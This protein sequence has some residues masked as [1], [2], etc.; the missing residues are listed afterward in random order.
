MT[1]IGIFGNT[2]N[3]P[4]LLATGFR[5]LG[6]QVKLVVD[7]PELLHRPEAKAGDYSTSYPDW[8]MDCAALGE[9]QFIAESPRICDAIN[10][11]SSGCRATVLNHIGPSLS[12]RLRIPALS[13]LSGS[14]L[15]YYADYRS[16]EMR[17]SR[18]SPDFVRSAGGRLAEEKWIEFVSR[19]RDGILSSMAVSFPYPGLVPEGD[20]LLRSIGVSD[21]RRFFIYIADT[22]NLRPA[23]LRKADKTKLILLNG[24]RLTWKKPL[25][26]G[27][28][29]Q[30]DKGTDI[31]LRGFAEFVKQ[32]RKGELRMF[33]KG[34]H[35]TETELL[36]QEL[37]IE[38]NIT[39]I[40]ELP[41]AGFWQAMREADVVCDQLGASFPGMVAL[42]AMA[43]GRPVLAN[44]RLDIMGSFFP[45]DIPVCNATTA[46]EVCT[47]LETLSESTEFR[48]HLGLRARQFAERYLS[49][50]AN[51]LKCLER[52]DLPA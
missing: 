5:K 17:R 43:L 48:A 23:A 19:Q 16:A 11:V 35:T 9:D 14:D 47:Q 31:L 6:H 21:D 27:F 40:D 49:P 3:Y 28:S 50:E 41:L 2:N 45:E 37:G 7:R 18:W 15:T 34:L 8:I 38:D 42:D 4:Y 36:I 24:A 39:W 25:P 32:G 12:S 52:L 29:S 51:A 44:F 10:F 22:I 1:T 20:A 13:L 33:R 46:A 26:D 30:D